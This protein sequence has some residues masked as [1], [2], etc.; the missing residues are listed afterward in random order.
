MMAK[1][2]LAITAIRVLYELAKEAREL[3]K[4]FEEDDP[5]DGQKHGEKKKEAV[6]GIIEIIYETVDDAVDLPLETE[7]V[8][9]A[10]DKL[11]EVLVSFYNAIGQFRG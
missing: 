2:S 4:L 1:I 8:I 5:D 11:I 6:L 3:V 10:M 7:K 9:E